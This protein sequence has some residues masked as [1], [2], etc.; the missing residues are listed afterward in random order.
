M[1]FK[2]IKFNTDD[3]KKS[4]LV[5]RKI[6]NFN[7]LLDLDSD[8]ISKPLYYQGFRER[9]FMSLLYEEISEGDVCIDLGSNIGFTTLFMSEKAGKTGKVYAIEPDPWNVN[10][11][12]QNITRNG[13]DHNTTVYEVAVSDKK[14]EIEF[15]Q[16]EKSNLS[17]VQKTKHSTKSIKV[18]GHSLETFLE[19]KDYPNFIKMDI[20]GHEVKVFEGALN[21]FKNNHKGTTRILLEVHPHFYNEE[22]NFEAILKEFFSIGFKTKYVVSTPNPRPAKFVEA[23]YTPLAEIPTDGFVRGLYG[24]ISD[25]HLLEFACR[26]N[27][28]GTSKK[29]VRS[30]ML[31]RK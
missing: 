17:S 18:Q 24:P 2:E 3:A 7:F 20:E 11:L 26:E 1:S 5:E 28:E 25:E 31:E 23:G 9:V 19:D 14:A 10:M 4:S 12:K 16:S 8:G 13:F 22:N 15:W 30:F 21:Y 29:I 27:I 6:H